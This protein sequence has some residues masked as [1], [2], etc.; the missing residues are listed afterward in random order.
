MKCSRYS[1]RVSV[2]GDSSSV[3]ELWNMNWEVRGPRSAERIVAMVGFG[4]RWL[5][6]CS[7]R[8]LRG[9]EFSELIFLKFRL[10][11]FTHLYMNLYP[12][13]ARSQGGFDWC[14]RT[15]PL[16]S[17]GGSTGS[18]HIYDIAYIHHIPYIE[19]SKLEI[20]PPPS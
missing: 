13:H 6:A 2:C 5:S 7:W 14:D 15:P 11:C 1:T 4:Q 12:Q 16:A 19:P 10:L 18:I 3:F 20:E 8:P 9:L 17:Q